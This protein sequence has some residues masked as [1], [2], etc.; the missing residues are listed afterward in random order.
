MSSQTIAYFKSVIKNSKELTNKEKD[1]LLRRL[2]HKTLK[3]IARKYK[4]SAERI[5]QL[6]E[7]ALDKFLRKACQLILIE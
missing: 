5:R 3:K 1:I 4:L 6:E 2:T 7:S